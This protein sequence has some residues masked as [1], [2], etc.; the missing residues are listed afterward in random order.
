MSQPTIWSILGVAPG[1]AERD[2]KRAYAAR[3]KLTHPEDDPE[4]FKALREAYELA[5]RH[6]KG[7]GYGRG[8]CHHPGGL[9][10]S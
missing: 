1:S 9:L 8:G 6:A 10:E 4:G 7:G 5:L 3:L 2:I